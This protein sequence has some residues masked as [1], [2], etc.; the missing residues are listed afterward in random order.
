MNTETTIAS[1]RAHLRV[2]GA[3]AAAFL[4]LLALGAEHG[5]SGLAQHLAVASLPVAIGLVGLALGAWGAL[6]AQLDDAD[7]VRLARTHLEAL[8]TWA[9]IALGVHA[10]ALLAAGDMSGLALALILAL[11]AGA[12]ALRIAPEPE[13]TGAT[14]PPSAPPRAPEPSP[15]PTGPVAPT[16]GSLWAGR[17]AR[18]PRGSTALWNG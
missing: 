17:D 10:L 12:V 3:A 6:A 18:R 7:T 13:Q 4:A 9:L 15:V 8:S 16:D 14:P 1:R 5:P 2:G 11:A